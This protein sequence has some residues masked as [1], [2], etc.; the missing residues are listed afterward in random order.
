M[1]L[2]DKAPNSYFSF[3]VEKSYMTHNC[4]WPN[5]TNDIDK[6][7]KN[8]NFRMLIMSA[9]VHIYLYK[10]SLHHIIFSLPFPSILRL[11]SLPG[12][13]H[14][15]VV[16]RLYLSPLPPVP[17]LVYW[18]DLKTPDS[19]KGTWHMASTLTK[20]KGWMCSQPP[21]TPLLLFPLGLLCILARFTGER[22]RLFVP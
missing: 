20:E 8:L 1:I 5:L 22:H 14:S 2:I 11:P 9:G 17:V 15:N 3:L 18:G 12:W 21:F 4:Y 13:P 7:H 19:K 10:F 6:R 16:E